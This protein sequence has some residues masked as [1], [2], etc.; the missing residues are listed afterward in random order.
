MSLHA[1]AY[2]TVECDAPGCTHNIGDGSDY[3]AWSTKGDAADIWR[4]EC[5]GVVLPDGTAYC[6]THI[7]P[8]ICR[9]NDDFKHRWND[10][11]DGTRSCL[12]CGAERPLS[13]QGNGDQP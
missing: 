11:E 12:D 1:V 5:Y 13:V 6:E 4:D 8:D 2:W 3:T 9:D 7:P 10:E